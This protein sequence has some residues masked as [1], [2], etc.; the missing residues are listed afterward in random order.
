MFECPHCAK[1]TITTRGKLF[2]HSSKKYECHNCGAFWTVKSIYAYFNIVL[3]VVVTQFLL[4]N[5]SLHL[6]VVFMFL[7]M[8]G[9]SVLLLQP[10]KKVID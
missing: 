9:I 8:L 2:A 7:C 4:R 1:K 5:T 6:V 10:L 3:G